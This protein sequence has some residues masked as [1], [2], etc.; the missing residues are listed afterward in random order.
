[1]ETDPLAAIG[2]E[3][4]PDSASDAE[5]TNEMESLFGPGSASESDFP[6]QPFESDL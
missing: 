5:I 4:E 6:A 2:K 3:V 1:M